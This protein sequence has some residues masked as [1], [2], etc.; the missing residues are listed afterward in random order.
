MIRRLPPVLSIFFVVFSS[1]AQQLPTT[2]TKKVQAQ[3]IDKYMQKLHEIGQYNGTVLVA[4]NGQVIYKNAFGYADFATKRK[5]R[6]DSPF[7]LGSV[8]KQ[9]TT[10]AVM[11]LAEEGRLSYDDSLHIYFPDFPEYGRGV[12]IRHLMTHTS[13]IA[14]HFSLGIY[15]PGLNNADVYEALN[16]QSALAFAPGEK[17]AYSNGGYVLLAMI[18][19]KVSGQSLHRFMKKNIFKPLKMR[20]SL[21]FHPKS[22]KIRARALG[23]KATGEPDDYVIFT[24]G[25]GGLYSTIEDLLKWDQ[26]LYTDRLVSPATLAEAFEAYQ[27][28]DGTLTDYGFGWRIGTNNQGGKIVGHSGS[29]NGFRTFIERDLQNRRTILLLTNHTNLQLKRIVEALWQ[30]QSDQPYTTPKNTSTN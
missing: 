21:V 29:L 11:M 14:D 15:R 4:E 28:K 23:H 13:G 17:Y 16:R 30:I 20:N 22:G 5:L 18:V 6:T 10:M 12:T 24:T 3:K 1:Y 9:F 8:S 19:E 7:Y 25:A 26:A 2:I 27:L